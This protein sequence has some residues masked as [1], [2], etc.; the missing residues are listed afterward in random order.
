MVK[1]WMIMIGTQLFLLPVGWQIF[2]KS[3][4]DGT[5][6]KFEKTLACLSSATMPWHGCRCRANAA[7]GITKTKGPNTSISSE[8]PPGWLFRGHFRMTTEELRKVG[9]AYR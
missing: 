7:T 8:F 6:A 5:A 4:L 9:S 1:A 2:G 3:F